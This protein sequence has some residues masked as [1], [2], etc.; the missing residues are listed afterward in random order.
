[1]PGEVTDSALSVYRVLDLTNHLGYLCGKI[2]GDLGADV[3]KV[4]SPCGDPIRLEGPFY[5]DDPDPN[6]NLYWWSYNNNKRGITLNLETT[7]GQEIFKRLVSKADVVIESFQP[8]YMSGLGLGYADLQKVNPKIIMTSITPF[9]QQGPYRDFKASDLTISAMGGLMGIL[10]DDDRPPVRAGLTQSY[11]W[12][13]GQAA[14]AT[15]TAL[16]YKGVTGEGQQV[17]VSIQG[18]M[19]VAQAHAPLFADIEGKNTKRMGKYVTGRSKHGA[20]HP[21]VHKCKDGHITWAIYGGPTGARTNKAMTQWMVDEGKADEYLINKDWDNFIMAE[22]TQEEMDRIIGSVA[23][24]L[25]G[26]T[27]AEFL[28]GAV[29]RGIMGYPVNTVKDILESPQLAARDYWTEMEHPELGIA[30]K[31]PGPFAK[32]SVTPPLVSRRAPLIGEHNREILG[33]ELGMSDS[34]LLRL[35]QQKVI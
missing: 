31:Y 25:S 28:E 32:L 16:F 13:G 30:I 33:Q 6:K 21:G 23:T 5:Q 29:A 24:F 35:K 12:G 1:M 18:S 8:G 26:L 10:G 22:A 20:V 34:E 17:D 3:I 27:K 9:G 14:F 7:D 11:L 2:L 4:E 15:I 19:I